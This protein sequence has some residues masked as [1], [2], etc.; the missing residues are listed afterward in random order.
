MTSAPSRLRPVDL[1]HASFVTHIDEALVLYVA[2]MGYPPSTAS[3]RRRLWLEHMSRVGWRAVGCFDRADALVGVAYGYQ[4]LPGQWWYN[5]VR[6]GFGGAAP[7]ALADYFELTEL[8][9][10]P[11]VQGAGLGEA[12]LRRLL[13]GVG[14]ASVLLSTPEHGP[15][16]P[17]RAWRLY[18]R[19]GFRDVLRHHRFTGDDRAFAVL[20]RDLPLP[21]EAGRSTPRPVT[22]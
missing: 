12:L 15:R 7:A 4:G 8:H 18:L 14:S 5:E 1:D 13:L 11:G 10:L 17:S 6:R 21:P 16:P 20:G 22:P 2:A 3:H 19:L 9:V